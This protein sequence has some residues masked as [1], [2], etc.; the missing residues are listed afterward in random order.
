MKRYVVHRLLQ[1][2]VVLC[3]VATIVFFLGRATGNP[4]DLMLPE[5][6]TPA[7]RQALIQTLGLDGPLWRQY[8]IFAGKALQGDLG[9]SIRMR[10]P[11]VEAFLSRLPNTFAI[12]P[13]ALVL[14]MCVGIPLGVLAAL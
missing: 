12:I 7:A 9:N 1:G 11:A 3:L 6:A 2:L 8:V 4:V 10:Q 13:W 5:D 14:A